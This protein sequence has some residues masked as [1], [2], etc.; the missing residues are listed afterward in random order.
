M[1]YC[2][3][4]EVLGLTFSSVAKVAI[5]DGCQ[6]RYELVLVFGVV[7]VYTRGFRLLFFCPII[8]GFRRRRRVRR[9]RLRWPGAGPLTVPGYKFGY[10]STAV[11]TLET[12]N[13]IPHC[14]ME[15]RSK[16]HGASTGPDMKHVLIS[17]R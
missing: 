14:S 1:N 16:E 12:E 17:C 8:A 6:G 4:K 5:S 13:N 15:F 7:F 11:S 2:S 9:R 10:Q 3:F